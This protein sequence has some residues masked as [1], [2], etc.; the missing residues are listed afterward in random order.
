MKI[1]GKTFLPILVPV[2]FLLVAGVFRPL[3]T[4][5][6]AQAD[7]ARVIVYYFHGNYRCPTCKKIERLS[8][9]TVVD[10]F[11]KE[12]SKGEL[13]YRVVN[14]EEPG[15]RHFVDDF[16]LFTKS[17]VLV[18][19]RDGKTVRHKNLSKIWVLIGDEKAFK[20]YVKEEVAAFMKQAGIEKAD[21]RG[22]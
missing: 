9:E 11:K 7:H 15:D 1:L 17:I 19:E 18:E 20:D 21:A 6:A 14:V 2:V 22:V 12:L 4:A 13:I 5:A 10:N 8:H 16:G 3:E